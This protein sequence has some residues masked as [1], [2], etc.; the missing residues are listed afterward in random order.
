MNEQMDEWMKNGMPASLWHNVISLCLYKNVKRGTK[1]KQ[2]SKE[3]EIKNNVA[4]I[5]ILLSHFVDT[6]SF[7]T[8]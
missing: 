5:G 2:A 8:A 4:H 6:H 3:N 1:K 7:L